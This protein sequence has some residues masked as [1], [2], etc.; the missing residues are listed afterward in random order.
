[1]LTMSAV[2]DQITKYQILHLI[3][4]MHP[5]VAK[6]GNLVKRSEEKNNVNSKNMRTLLKSIQ[7]S[8][9]F[10]LSDLNLQYERQPQIRLFRLPLTIEEKIGYF[11]FKLCMC[12][13]I[14]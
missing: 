7:L 12:C 8:Y 6:I 3:F 2:H 10:G 1:M 14:R 4:F 9:L 11:L 13:F 5:L